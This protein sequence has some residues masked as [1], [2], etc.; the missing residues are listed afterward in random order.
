MISMIRGK[1]AKRLILNPK[2]FNPDRKKL[3]FMG[4]SAVYNGLLPLSFDA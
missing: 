3:Q 4:N 1:Y 2:P